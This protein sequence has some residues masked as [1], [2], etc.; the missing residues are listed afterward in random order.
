MHINDLL[1]E[2][3][4]RE[5]SDL[6]ITTG[7]P[8]IIRVYG[9]LSKLDYP[10]LTAKDTLAMLEEVVTEEQAEQFAEFRDIDFSYNIEGMGRFR[11][12]AYRQRG[13][14]GIAFRVIPPEVIP[15]NNLGLPDVVT[16]LSR[17]LSGIILVVGP[18]GHGKTTTLAGM[19]DIINTE[20][21]CHIVTIEDPIEYVHR[22]KKSIINQR[23]VGIDAQSFPRA[24]RA[25][26]REDPDVI[27]VGEMRDLDTI[28]TAITAAE[29]GHLVLTTLHSGDAA[30][31]IDRIIDVFP[32]HQ[33][34]QVK[35]QLSVTLQGV[36][37]QQLIPRHDRPGRVVATEVM[38][39]TPAVRNL[40]R[41]GKTYQIPSIIQSGIRF[42]MQT[43]DTSLQ[44]LYRG[45]KI[46]AAE[47]QSRVT[48]TEKNVRSAEA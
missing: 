7:V 48:A 12:N 29:T 20:R 23:E 3:I 14:I 22:H 13:V 10:E 40:I 34:G 30:T 15:L 25:A 41:E 36:I 42:G 8:P 9:E 26:L 37:A 38:I 33:Q 24:L 2:A 35:I 47:Y 46:S 31:A 44:N 45:G 6:H 1:A 4:E 43:M 11:V 39:A 18:T 5:A 27:L 19:I 16:D 21:G 32:P 17:K 28:A